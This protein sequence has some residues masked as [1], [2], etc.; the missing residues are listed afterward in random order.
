MIL[1]KDIEDYIRRIGLDA[2][3][4]DRY[5]RDIDVIPSVNASME[6]LVGILSRVV[7]KDKF[8]EEK[9]SDLK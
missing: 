5:L 7:G 3:G 2:E 6:W 4:S 9:L 1:L 8:V